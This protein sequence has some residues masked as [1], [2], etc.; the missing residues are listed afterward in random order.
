MKVLGFIFRF[1]ALLILRNDWIELKIK[2][3]AVYNR[4]KHEEDFIPSQLL[5]EMLIVAEDRRYWN[6]FGVDF[7]SI[8]RALLKNFIYG[9]K[10]GGSTIE[11]QLVRVINCRY[12]KTI[13]RKIVEI[14]FAVLLSNEIPKNEIPGVYLSIAYY[15]W[16]MNGLKQ[17]FTHMGINNR[18][19]NDKYLCACL[20]ARLKY[21]E[22]EYFNTAWSYR[23]RRRTK[24]IVNLKALYSK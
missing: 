21:P 7:I 18:D 22:T 4:Y 10:E 9:T 1:I 13:K 19:L 14:L 20:I 12:E 3:Y 2:L 8:T 24:Y 16:K 6:H 15:G 11:Q 23:V 17:A 5:T